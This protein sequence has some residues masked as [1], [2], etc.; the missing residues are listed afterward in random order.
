[1]LIIREW[2]IR[3]QKNATMFMLRALLAAAYAGC[4]AHECARD[5]NG[6]RHAES[7]DAHEMAFAVI[8][9]DEAQEF[10]ILI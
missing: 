10:T 7:Y 3:I 4:H 9:R 5:I 6:A 2:P 1:M 8:E